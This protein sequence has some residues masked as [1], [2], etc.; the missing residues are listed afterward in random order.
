MRASVAPGI[1]PRAVA[2][3][4]RGGGQERQPA[5][6]FA[7]GLLLCAVIGPA[8]RADNPDAAV[9]DGLRLYRADEFDKARA[10][11]AEA[12]EAFATSDAAKS[13]IAAFDEACAAHRKGDV[14]HAR[15]SYLQAGL[16][17]DKALAAAAHFNL[18]TLASEEARR[19]AG[20]NPESVAAEKRP[21]II[22]GLKAAVASFR[23]SLELEPENARARRDI[24]LVRQWIKY[25]SDR[26][27]QHDRE[28]RRQEMNLIAFLEFLIET[29]RALRESVKTLNS[30]TPT[31]AFAEMKRLQDELREEISPLKDKIKAELQPQPAAGASGA[32]QGSSQELEKGIALLQ[33]WADTAGAKMMSAAQELLSRQVEPA[34][35]DQQAAIDELEKIWDAVI[36]FHP[37]LVRDLADQTQIAG[38]LKP[39]EPP[40]STKA[41]DGKAAEKKVAGA[42]SRCAATAEFIAFGRRS[43][44]LG[45][46]TEDLARLAETQE[47]TQR[48]TQLLKLKAEAELARV[49][50]Q[51]P[52]EAPKENKEKMPARTTRRTRRTGR[53]NRSI[54]RRSRR[55]IRR[56]SSCAGSR[57]E[58]GARREGAREEGPERCLPAG[59]G[60]EEDSRRDPEAQPPQGR[61]KQDKKDQ[62]KKKDEQQK[63]DQ[64]DKKDEQKKQD[65]KD[66]EKKKDEQKKDERKDPEKKKDEQKKDEQKKKQDDQGK[67]E[68]EKKPQQKQEFSKDQIEEA[69]RKVRER[70]QEKRE[71]DRMLKAR[72]MGRAPVEKDW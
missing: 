16:A 10:K 61:R 40:D 38:A 15:E 6:P 72:V 2:A 37:L 9:R 28:K 51:P 62:D 23:H 39:E 44:V 64:K 27:V 3:A 19:L 25:Y 54:P 22:D 56:P 18:G 66:Q 65:Q 17:H 14:A 52:Q 32:P 53:R 33:G 21:E 41:A 34:A 46:E 31:D 67:S 42:K 26:W 30:T 57:Q 7:T 68:Q 69:L 58:D 29:Q 47:R 36:P 13:A 8:S 35:R 1:E 49:K 20:E 12:R 50:E 4:A 60:S 63:Q 43:G 48:R 55:A 71:R 11:F 59:R 70:Q 5:L 45:S 24:E